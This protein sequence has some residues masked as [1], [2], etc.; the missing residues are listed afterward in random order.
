MLANVNHQFYRESSPS[1]ALS[2]LGWPLSTPV[3]DGLD[4]VEMGRPN[5]NVGGSISPLGLGLNR[6][7]E[8]TSLHLYFLSSDSIMFNK[9]TAT[10]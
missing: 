9:M 4:Y 10:P 7:R 1:E 5:L 8:M 2:R 6:K 3:R